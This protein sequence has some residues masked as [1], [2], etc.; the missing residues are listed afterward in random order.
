MRAQ[1]KEIP[2]PVLY[3]LLMKMESACNRADYEEIRTLLMR[4]VDEYQPQCGIEDFIWSG[5][6]KAA[7]K[8]LTDTV[9]V[10]LR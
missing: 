9:V 3:D 2:W 4:A 1:E 7:E 5:K 8:N 10:Q 6:N